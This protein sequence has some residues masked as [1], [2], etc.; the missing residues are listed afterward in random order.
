[1]SLKHAEKSIL[2]IKNIYFLKRIKWCLKFGD[3]FIEVSMG[4][5]EIF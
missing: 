5:L 2:K 4:V 3:G 1:M